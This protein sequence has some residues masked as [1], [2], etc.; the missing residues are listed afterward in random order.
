[1]ARVTQT[2]AA[3]WW[4]FGV[5]GLCLAFGVDGCGGLGPSPVPGTKSAVTLLMGTAPDSLDPAAGSNA[6]ALESDWLA[7]TPLVTY[8]HASGI[9]GTQ[10]V[11]GLATSLPIIVN[12]GKTYI[13]TLRKGL[14]YSNGRPVEA[15][16]FSWTLERAIKLRRRAAQLIVGTVMGAAQFSAG[17]AK[18]VAGISTN[19]A[20]GRITIH[21]LAP[22][23]AFANLLAV[24]ALGLVPRGTPMRDMPANPP[25]GVGPY[26][27]TNVVPGHSFSLV[28]NPYWLRVNVPDV[29]AGELNV[30]VKISTNIK[31]NALA[32]LNNT[33]DVFDSADALPGELSAQLARRAPDRFSRQI[34]AASDLVFLNV[35]NKPF[36]SQLTR[37]AV[38]TA[39]ADRSIEP[40]GSQ[41]LVPGCYLLPPTVIGYPGPPCFGRDHRQQDGVARS[42]GLVRRA[43][44]SGARVT[45]WSPARR[46]IRQWMA[47]YT[48]LL[49]RLGFRAHETVIPD[50]SYYATIGES[51]VHPQTG[52]G[53]VA[54]GFPDPLAF[55]EA[56][57][58]LKVIPH[59][60]QNWGE[61]DD[62]HINDELR[63]LAT[64]PEPELAAVA[65]MWQRLEQYTEKRA[66]VAVLGYET[67]P[68]F[69][70]ARLDYRKLI[71]NP[72]AGFDWSSVRLN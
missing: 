61:V 68:D 37:Q 57:S 18:V 13:V 45:V 4:S 51:G 7:Y 8:A 31:A 70:S 41:T 55:Y 56:L 71:F 59:R 34:T 32:V 50:R 63:T 52:F 40:V 62:P 22:Y 38:M 65:G 21:L 28:T 15:S 1:M 10:L 29:P 39:L 27:I 43:A 26:L 36:S 66:Y 64:V 48:L 67:A 35:S 6:E 24:P 42:Q 11:P 72:V 53:V 54:P 46:P 19:N 49:N 14:V 2:P 17:K 58:T 9:A 5:L 16:D 23:G 44:M 12:R 20:T 33:S 25:P 60:N 3:R 47:N 30:N 69:V